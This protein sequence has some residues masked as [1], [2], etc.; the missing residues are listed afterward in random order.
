MN[1]YIFILLYSH[2]NLIMSLWI[3]CQHLFHK[4]VFEIEEIKNT[5]LENTFVETLIQFFQF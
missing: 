2:L 5:F 4:L 1:I 3:G